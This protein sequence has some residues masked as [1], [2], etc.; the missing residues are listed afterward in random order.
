MKQKH[1]RIRI[2]L[3]GRAGE[4]FSQLNGVTRSNLINVILN[5]FIQLKN[6]DELKKILLF[7]FSSEEV[8]ELLKRDNNDKES[9]QDNDKESNNKKKTFNDDGKWVNGIPEH[10]IVTF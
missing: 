10:L 6:G 8:E 9:N 4:F 3:R 5:S 7:H 1:E 2:T